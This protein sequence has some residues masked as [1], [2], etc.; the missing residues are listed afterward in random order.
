[1]EGET[2]DK[3]A[4]EL[5]PQDY[6]AKVKAAYDIKQNL[7]TLFLKDEEGVEKPITVDSLIK[8]K[9]N[10]LY[11]KSCRNSKYKIVQNV[12]IVKVLIEDCHDCEVSLH[13]KILTNVVEVWKCE[14]LVLLVDT[15]VFT[16]QVDLCKNLTI[17]Y[18]HKKYLGSIVQA[19]VYGFQIKFNDYPELGFST[20]YD[21]LVKE[22]EG[23]NDKTDQ[24]ITRFVEGALLTEGIV[25]LDN[26]FHSTERERSAFDEQKDKNDKNTEEELRKM[27]KLAGPAMG[28]GEKDLHD[29]SKKGK[30]ETEEEQKKEQA[31]NLKKHLGNKHLTNK[32]Y[33]KAISAYTEGLVIYEK[34][35]LLHSNR[36]WAYMLLKNWEKALE[37]AN[38]CIELQSDFTKAHFRKGSILLELGRIEEAVAALTEAHDLE[39]K[40]EEILALLDQAK[41]RK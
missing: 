2:K 1:M 37:D 5:T 15:D 39:P 12:D 22:H 34:S 19:G 40:D 25:R 14:N 3:A 36:C 8:K 4:E 13:G 24:F 27:L 18:N 33:E 38:K 32:E 17:I 35:H 23:I 21:E 7:E 6:L 20:G 29:K 41:S 16:L 31:A 9:K 11:V 26:G 10:A 30:E 28:F